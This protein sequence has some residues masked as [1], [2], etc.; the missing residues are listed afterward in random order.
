MT[1]RRP[2]SSA[3]APLMA[4]KALMRARSIRRPLIGKFST[5]RCVWACHLAWDGT[6]TSPMESC[7][8]RYSLM[9][10]TLRPSSAVLVGPTRRIRRDPPTTT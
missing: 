3:A 4:A 1:F 9:A 7:S 10:L 8:M 5:A 6:R 2:F